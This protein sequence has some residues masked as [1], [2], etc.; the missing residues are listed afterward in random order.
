MG[1]LAPIEIFLGVLLLCAG[2][3]P[4]ADLATEVVDA[5]GAMFILLW[6]GCLEIE[7]QA[8]QVSRHVE[9]QVGLLQRLLSLA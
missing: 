4:A 7:T 2:F 1:A 3:F 8:P 9:A 5:F 6:S